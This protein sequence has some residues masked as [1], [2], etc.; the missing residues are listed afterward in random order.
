MYHII[1]VRGI[2]LKPSMKFNSEV[3]LLLTSGIKRLMDGML[4]NSMAFLHALTAALV[5]DCQIKAKRTH[6]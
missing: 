3:D 6:Q 1:Q 2:D 5:D 4:L